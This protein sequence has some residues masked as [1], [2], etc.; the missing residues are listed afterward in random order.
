MNCKCDMPERWA[1]DPEF[2]IEFDP[3]MNEY[4][5]VFG[6]NSGKYLIS[7]CPKCGGKMPESKR[8]EYFMEPSEDEV[9]EMRELLQKVKDVASMRLILGEPDYFSDWTAEEERPNK[10]YTVERFKRQYTYLS[11]WQSLGI[12]IEEKD[13]GS[14]SYVWFGKEKPKQ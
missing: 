1:K 13:D 6:K 4:Y 11:K 3:S 9:L 10:F 7:F 12:C 5:I 8:G 14:L 2:P